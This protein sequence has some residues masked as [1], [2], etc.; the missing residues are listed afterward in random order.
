MNDKT[1]GS[2]APGF[3][4]SI[5]IILVSAALVL[6]LLWATSRTQRIPVFEQ[7]PDW[8]KSSYNAVWTSAV[9]GATG[10]GLA[11][12]KVFTR[13]PDDPRPN[14]LL[15][16]MV[17]TVIL[18]ILIFLLPK[19]FA[20][21]NRNY[22]EAKVVS[23]GFKPWVPGSQSPGTQ[24]GQPT[25]V[26]SDANVDAKV[27]EWKDVKWDVSYICR[28][29]GLGGTDGTVKWDTPD[30]DISKVPIAAPEYGLWGTMTFR[31]LQ[32][33]HY[34]VSMDVNTSCLDINMP[35]NPCRSHG[36]FQ[37]NVSGK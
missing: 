34:T 37:V 12:V 26:F 24:C 6:F 36:E 4:D 33:G 19:V 31:Y 15:W 11:I 22:V 3:L 29:Q 21:P 23:G 28:R 35:P 18:L 30:R 27:E 7:L 2:S 1:R 14:Y 13:K 10:I 5:I 8:L 32:P 17:V 20:Q 9:S 16:I 25:I